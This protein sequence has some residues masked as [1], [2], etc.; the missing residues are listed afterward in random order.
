V[1]GQLD[2][3][4]R[5]PAPGVRRGKAVTPKKE[6]SILDVCSGSG[7]IALLLHSMLKKSGKFPHLKTR[8]L[9]ISPQAVALANEN[10]ARNAKNGHFSIS[11]FRIKDEGSREHDAELRT[12]L[13]GDP[14]SSHH[15]QHRGGGRKFRCHDVLLYLSRLRGKEAKISLSGA[16]KPVHFA[17]HDIFTSLPRSL[18]D[19]SIIISNPPYISQSAF[20]KETTRSVRVYEPKLALVPD[21]E[22]YPKSHRKMER[23]EAWKSGSTSSVYSWTPDDAEVEKKGKKKKGDM[24][25]DPAD[26]FYRQLLKIYDWKG[27]K[28]LLMEVGDAEQALRVVKLALSKHHIAKTNRFEIWRDY[29]AQSSQTGEETSLDVEGRTI[30]IKGAGKMRAIVLFRVEEKR[31]KPDREERWDEVPLAYPKSP[32][33]TI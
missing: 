21:S 33:A 29:P 11:A 20:M 8:G 16:D 31:E 3:Q 14:S 32:V 28:I 22:A 26:I 18:G 2:E 13:G 4:L 19:P 17:T 9:D 24:E 5:L 7:C 1:T 15:L 27:S 12:A 30:P 25:V 23:Y 10:L 6:L